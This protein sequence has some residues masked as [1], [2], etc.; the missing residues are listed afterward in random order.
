VKLFAGMTRYR[1]ITF[2]MCTTMVFF[3]SKIS[4][5]GRHMLPSLLLFLFQLTFVFLLVVFRDFFSMM[6]LDII[7]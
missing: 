3:R 6:L 7:K 1:E 4:T 2:S 5:Q